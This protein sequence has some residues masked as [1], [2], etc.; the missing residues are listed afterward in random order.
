MYYIQSR[1]KLEGRKLHYYGLRNADN[2]F[3]ND[4]ALSKKQADIVATLPRQLNDA[5]Y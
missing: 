4:I 2:M 1:W 3:K 5:N